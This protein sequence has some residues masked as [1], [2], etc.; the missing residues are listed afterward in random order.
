MKTKNMNQLSVAGF[1]NI[2]KG[3]A[4]E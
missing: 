4:N 1:I 2:N 3:A